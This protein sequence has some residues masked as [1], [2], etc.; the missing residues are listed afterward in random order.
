MAS[1]FDPPRKAAVN[2]LSSFC[3]KDSMQAFLTPFPVFL[4]AVPPDPG[5]FKGLEAKQ[6]FSSNILIFQT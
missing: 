2:I 3:G 6:P 4:E 5:I 1:V